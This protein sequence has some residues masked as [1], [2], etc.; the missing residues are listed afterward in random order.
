MLSVPLEFLI[1]TL[2]LLANGVLAMA[3]IAMVSARKARLRKLQRR[4]EEIL[5]RIESLGKQKEACQTEMGLSANYSDGAKMRR[6][7]ASLDELEAEAIR[8]NEEW[9][10]VTEELAAVP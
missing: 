4:E 3:E 6:L 8:L 10:A 1:I 7:Q 5:A 9:E 2:L